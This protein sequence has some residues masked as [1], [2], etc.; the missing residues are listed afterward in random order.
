MAP[1]HHN[2]FTPFFSSGHRHQYSSASLSP[3]PTLPRIHLCIV[4]MKDMKFLQV[5]HS[6]NWVEHGRAMRPSLDA[7]EFMNL[8]HGLDLMKVKVNWSKNEVPVAGEVMLGVACGGSGDAGSGSW[9]RVVTHVADGGGGEGKWVI[10][11]DV[12]GHYGEWRQ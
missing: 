5:I 3:P 8:L 7:N 2:H 10:A 9:V 12:A 1:P 4:D 11:V 6:S